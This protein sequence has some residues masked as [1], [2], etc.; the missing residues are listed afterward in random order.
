MLRLTDLTF[1]VGKLKLFKTE[2]P[3]FAF[4][5]DCFLLFREDM[6]AFRDEQ[7]SQYVSLSHSPVLI[8]IRKI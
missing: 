8:H 1:K 7:D 6:V 2:Y 4:M 3:I 5:P